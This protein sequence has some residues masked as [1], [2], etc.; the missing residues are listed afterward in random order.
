M[1]EQTATKTVRRWT[2]FAAFLVCVLRVAA[3]WGDLEIDE[4]WTLSIAVNDIKHFSQ[5]LVQFHDNNHMV[6]T[7]VLYLM[8]R[9]WPDD[10]YRIFPVIASLGSV[11]LAALITKRR[12]DSLA[13]LAAVVLVGTSHVLVLYG[14]EA[15]GYTYA[16]FFSYLAWMSLLRLESDRRWLDAALFAVSASLGFMSHLT[17]LYAY[18]G[19]C[20]WTLW[21]W[22]RRPNWI[23]PLS[24]VLPFLVAVFYFLIFIPRMIIGGG[25]ETT[26]FIAI[27]S[28][29][30]I[31]L[32]GPLAGDICLIAA[33]VAA[34]TLIAGLVSAFKTDLATAAFYLTTVFITPTA[35]LIV[36]GHSLVYPRYFTV[37]I[38]F[39]LLMI[40]E[41][42]S[43]WWMS[44]G[45][46]R[47][48]VIA[49]FGAY[50]LGNVWWDLLI[51]DH[52]RG[53]YAHAIRWMSAHH[54]DG[55]ATVSGDHD[56]RHGVMLMHHSSHYPPGK[57]PLKYLG[58]RSIP[59]EGTDWLF[60]HNFDGDA[61][62]PDTVVA[63]H[64]VEYRL[65]RIFHHHGMAGWNLWV[66]KR[67]DKKH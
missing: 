23:M 7:F 45:W 44:G 3:A 46:R 1:T 21:K 63:A 65:E 27:S 19:F 53:D 40:S 36:T 26:M 54:P 5:I 42:A 56:F 13:T 64:G 51:L 14:A 22:L 11:W 16:I 34:L 50:L 47:S 4:I 30:S 32:G 38:A 49:F 61:L 2:I 12:A 20:V 52:G 18:T 39:A 59:A 35:V 31:F 10:C 28:S 25:P 17:Y 62:R 29:L 55:P 60:L 41:M 33:L 58:G 43:R 8:G 37:S 15:R 48:T 24:H 66:Y 67:V 57:F 6:N 9:G